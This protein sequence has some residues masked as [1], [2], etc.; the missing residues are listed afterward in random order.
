MDTSDIE[1]IMPMALPT[2]YRILYIRSILYRVWM[3][4]ISNQDTV[5]HI[6]NMTHRNG[7]MECMWYVPK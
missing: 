7:V 3:K 1:Y 4:K 5:F 6:K 2:L